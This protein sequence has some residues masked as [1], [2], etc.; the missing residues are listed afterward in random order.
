MLKKKLTF[1]I[2]SGPTK[3]YIDPV[4]FISNE[5]SGKMGNALARSILKKNHRVIFVSGPVSVFPTGVKLI[6]I[7]T[8]LEMFKEVKTNFKKA[9]I[10]IG[11]AA[12]ADYRPIKVH[13][14]KIKK[15]NPKMSIEVKRNPDIIRYCG[16]NKKNQIVVGFALE[17]SDLV[18]NAKLKLES[19]N[20]DLI[21]AN[22]KESFNS[23]NTTV[24]MIN[25]DDVI[26]EIKNRNKKNIAEKIINE[27]IRIFEDIKFDKKIF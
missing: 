4:R 5:S 13:R 21:I 1:L 16:K 15:D 2:F 12:I 6:K 26:L 17:T 27:T 24:F 3:E 14:H 7:T 9:D 10:V 18:D 23:N 25:Q 11:V 22:S 8:A 19:K 20:L